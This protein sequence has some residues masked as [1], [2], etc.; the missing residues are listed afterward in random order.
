MAR[1][2]IK[3]AR[4][5]GWWLLAPQANGQGHTVRIQKVHDQQTRGALPAG[6]GEV[7]VLSCLQVAPEHAEAIGAGAK[8]GSITGKTGTEDRMD[9]REVELLDAISNVVP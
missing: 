6:K 7:H 8:A 2:G 5:M 1:T 4:V 9:M 3:V